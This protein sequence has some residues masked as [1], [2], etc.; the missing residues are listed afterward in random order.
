MFDPNGLTFGQVSSSLKDFTI[1]G[2][3]LAVAWKARG[4]FDEMSNFITDI[5]QFMTRSTQH[6]K[7][8]EDTL[9]VATTNHLTH[10]ESDL[11][12][13]AGRKTD[14]VEVDDTLGSK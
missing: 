4:K 13:L 3:L 5:K 7:S 6:M 14:V 10:I 12:T 11:R 8:V 9:S 1:V 2:L